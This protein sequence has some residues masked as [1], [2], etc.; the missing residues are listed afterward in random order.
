MSGLGASGAAAVPALQPLVIGLA[1]ANPGVFPTLARQFVHKWASALSGEFRNVESDT[2]LF[3]FTLQ[4]SGLYMR[5]FEEIYFLLVPP[6][7]QTPLSSL[8]ALLEQ[9]DASH[10]F[11]VLCPHRQQYA[12]LS[13]GSFHGRVI[14]FSPEII[15]EILSSNGSRSREA[16]RRPIRNQIDAIR[17]HP[18][19]TT[20]PA[21]GEMFF[22]RQEE[23]NMLQT[24]EAAGF[25]ITGPSRTG[26]T[27]LVQQ[28]L[29]IC[30]RG[31]NPHTRN[32]FYLDLQ[33]CAHLDEDRI[34]RVFAMGIR[35]VPGITDRIQFS[36][37]RSF[38]CSIVHKVKE[39][40]EIIIDEA[41]AVCHTD[42]LLTVAE[43]AVSSG[44]RVIVV[45]RGAVRQF[46]RKH[47]ASS[48]G[49]LHEIRFQALSADE[50]WQLFL[51]P[52]EALGLRVET[53]EETKQTLLRYTSRNPHL[54][55]GCAQLVV[56]QA[57][58]TNTCTITPSMLAPT[59]ESF[60]DFS[61]LRTQLEDVH[62]DLARFAAVEVLKHSQ[63]GLQ[64]PTLI[65]AALCERGLACTMTEIYDAC[66][67][68]V[69]N[70]LLGWEHANYAPPRWDLF[71]TAQHHRDYLDGVQRECLERLKARGR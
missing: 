23:L 48:F 38:L 2:P 37:L 52:I 1:S 40:L 4:L 3:R 50:A 17:L 6:F 31:K 66:D 63:E 28:Y 65:R 22:G 34:A 41:D 13:I 18:F 21:T 56:R 36:E 55:Q 59:D 39:P 45:G 54:V 16:F 62:S 12:S 69:V 35:D 70:W 9:T 61:L 47:Q 42:L 57:S 68:L 14:I 64:V 46:W 60:R 19:N 15:S 32:V 44:N 20:Q 53:P 24:N 43:F 51:R 11:I 7:L 25:L 71:K 33:V 30:R 27:S 49:R 26:K 29:Q 67:D 58:T 10:P 8:P 5:G